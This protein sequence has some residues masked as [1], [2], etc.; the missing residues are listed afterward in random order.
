MIKADY[1]C[2]LTFP[3]N[4]TMQIFY[5]QFCSVL[6]TCFC[7]LLQPSSGSNTGSRKTVKKGDRSLLIR[8]GLNK[9][10]AIALKVH[11]Q[12]RTWYIHL[13]ILNSYSNL[14]TLDYVTDFYIWQ[15]IQKIIVLYSRK[16]EIQKSKTRYDTRLQEPTPS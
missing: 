7:S 6:H 15:H 2:F 13:K 3:N 16:Q 8:S 5:T 11:T 14:A 10:H 4:T 9:K 12:R 1:I